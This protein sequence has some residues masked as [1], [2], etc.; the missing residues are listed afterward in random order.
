LAQ[1][2]GCFFTY[3]FDYPFRS[4]TIENAS[5]EGG[6]LDPMLAWLTY[7]KRSLPTEKNGST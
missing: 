2:P 3:S 7:G 1:G 4:E 6:Y 5:F